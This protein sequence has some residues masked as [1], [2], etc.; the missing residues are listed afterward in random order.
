MGASADRYLDVSKFDVSNVG[1][2]GIEPAVGEDGKAV[3]T[4][5]QRLAIVAPEVPVTDEL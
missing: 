2:E 1:G 4:V 5:A 3:T